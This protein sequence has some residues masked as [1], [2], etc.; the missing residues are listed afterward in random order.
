M[1]RGRERKKRRK[2]RII[3]TFYR[4]QAL[5]TAPILTILSTLYKINC[6]ELFFI[7]LSIMTCAPG[8]R[9][10]QNTHILFSNANGTRVKDRR[11]EVRELPKQNLNVWTCIYVLHRKFYSLDFFCGFYRYFKQQFYIPNVWFSPQTH[12]H[13][14][15]LRGKKIVWYESFQNIEIVSVFL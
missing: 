6:F 1:E 5:A 2:Q 10:Y 7:Y 4:D 14:W 9:T 11:G 3:T 13:I 15:K 8:N 12:T